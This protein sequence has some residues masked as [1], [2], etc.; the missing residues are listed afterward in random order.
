VRS[1]ARRGGDERPCTSCGQWPCRQVAGRR[2]VFLGL[3]GLGALGIAFGARRKRSLVMSQAR[4]SAVCCRRRPLPDLLDHRHLPGIAPTAYRLKVSG[5]VERPATFTL[6]DLEAMPRT[7]LARD[8]QCVTG[9]RVPDVHWKGSGSRICSTRLASARGVSPLVR[10]LRRCRYREPHLDQG[11]PARRAGRLPHA[12]RTGDHRTRRPVR[13]YVAR[14]SAT[15][16]SSALGHPRRGPGRTGFY[17][18]AVNAGPRLTGLTDPGRLRS[19]A[20]TRA[21]RRVVRLVRFDRCSA[22]RT[23]RTLCCSP[24]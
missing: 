18:G 19:L 3:A 1:Y 20:V 8:F 5:L 15:S 7:K 21:R 16:P 24:S 23:G 6:A 22:A 13:L 17:S 9:W 12:R 4:G 11:A 14:C 2:R 10:V